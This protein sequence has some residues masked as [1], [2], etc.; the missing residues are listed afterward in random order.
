MY[1]KHKGDWIENK[2]ELMEIDDIDAK[3]IKTVSQT[4]GIYLR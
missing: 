2:G 3:D 1:A 4:V